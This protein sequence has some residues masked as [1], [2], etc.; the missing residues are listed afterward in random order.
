M[1]TSR[2]PVHTVVVDERVEFADLL[3]EVRRNEGLPVVLVVP[4]ASPLFLT[5]SEFR[6]LRE[7][8]RQFG[9][10]L[11]IETTDPHRVEF[12]R[13]FN[14]PVAGESRARREP[15]AGSA[16]R[17]PAAAG[18]AD[19]WPARHRRETWDAPADRPDSDAIPPRAGRGGARIVALVGVVALLLAIAAAL[20]VPSA[21]IVLVQ[22]RQSLQAQIAYR[23]VLPGESTGAEPTIPGQLE[24]VQVQVEGVAPSTGEQR[25][26]DHPATGEVVFAN[27]TAAAVTLGAGTVL[28]SADGIQARVISDVV[29]PA[30]NDRSSGTA[31]ALVSTVDGGEALNLPQGAFTGV[32][33]DGMYF[34]NRNR[35]FSEGPDAVTRFVQEADIAAATAAAGT[36]LA[37]AVLF[38]VQASLGSTWEILPAS[39]RAAGFSG[40]PNVALGTVADEVRVSGSAIVEVT[41]YETTA[42]RAL[43]L[44]ALQ[45]Q[46]PAGLAIDE[47][48]LTLLDPVPQP[49]VSPGNSLVRSVSVGAVRALG[50]GEVDAL[51]SAVRG[52]TSDSVLARARAI[53]GVAADGTT[54]RVEP[55]WWPDRLPLLAG[56][57]TVVTQ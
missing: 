39:L 38:A 4:D 48:S 23:V 35:G 53:P 52:E 3:L 24:T 31:S 34:S 22:E 19:T 57:I 41:V 50:D 32:T 7:T 5:A 1:S 26:P 54:V 16:S 42:V 13:L 11:T 30:A 47:A 2:G 18:P 51:T 56:R 21:T 14:L 33:L 45:G 49:G 10:P 20:I 43:A 36:N 27:P 8:A 25:I 15:G 29:V 9:I 46:T 6:A 28:T 44:A 37:V 17:P 55:G 12:A 40:V